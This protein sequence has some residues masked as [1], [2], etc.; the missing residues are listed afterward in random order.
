MKIDVIKSPNFPR[1]QVS[2]DYRGLFLS[3][4]YAAL[5]VGVERVVNDIIHATPSRNSASGYSWDTTLAGEGVQARVYNSWP[6]WVFYEKD[7]KRHWPPHA[8]GSRLDEWSQ[9][10]GMDTDYVAWLISQRG[11]AGHYIFRDH[12]T[13]GEPFIQATLRQATAQFIQEA[14]DFGGGV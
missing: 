11:T 6:Y 4:M 12:W 9:G 1:G 13:T 2:R 3:R 7:S 10:K 14:L 8:A 5:R